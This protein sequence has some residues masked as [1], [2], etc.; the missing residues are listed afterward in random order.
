MDN[1]EKKNSII[2][3]IELPNEFEMFKEP[4]KPRK[5]ETEIK[6]TADCIS[7]PEACEEIYPFEYVKIGYNKSTKTVLVS[8]CEEDDIYKIKLTKLTNF[9]KYIRAKIFFTNHQIKPQRITNKYIYN[10]SLKG[11]VFTVE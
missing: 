5:L 6:I 2:Q 4:R 3:S 7:I 9:R 11:I 8:V 10:E 1:I